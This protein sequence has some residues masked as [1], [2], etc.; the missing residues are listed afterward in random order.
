MLTEGLGMVTGTVCFW[1]DGLAIVPP[2]AT[3][4]LTVS[5][6][7]APDGY[8]LSVSLCCSPPL[9]AVMLRRV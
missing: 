9:S 5:V 2:L 6:S 3:L 1:H 4:R 7:Y 8:S